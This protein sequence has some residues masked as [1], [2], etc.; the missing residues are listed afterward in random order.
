MRE[1][2]KRKMDFQF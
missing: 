2:S 1:L